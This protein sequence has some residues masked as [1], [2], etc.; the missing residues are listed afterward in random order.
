M[1]YHYW[2]FF[3]VAERL[4]PFAREA[5]PRVTSFECG[6][7]AIEYCVPEP[8]VGLEVEAEALMREVA[9]E[10]ASH[11]EAPYAEWIREEYSLAHAVE[12]ELAPEEIARFV[13]GDERTLADSEVR[14]ILGSAVSY[15][16][17][18]RLV[19][20]WAG[21]YVEGSLEPAHELLRYA[22]VQ[23]LEF[24]RYDAQLTA[25]L[26]NAYADLRAF[27]RWSLRGKA[28]G[29]YRILLHIRESTERMDNAVKFLS[30]TYAARVY[31]LAASRVGVDDYRALVE[32]KWNTAQE[33]YRFM[34]DQFHHTR[35]FVLEFLVVAILVID[36]Y[37]LLVKELA[38]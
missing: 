22:N 24:R 35:A 34:L 15:Y 4:R 32:S 36:L 3:D 9:K 6:V 17:G 10:F 37:Y 8:R 31:R 21:A 7:V 13:R 38:R 28:Q 16:A 11:L 19:A 25:L 5:S 33:V 1:N 23:L 14:E 2:Y 20:G 26:G 29:L 27:R 30:D 18:D 12:G